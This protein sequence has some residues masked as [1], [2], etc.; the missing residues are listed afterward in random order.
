MF[1][2]D[3]RAKV[4]LTLKVTGRRPDGYHDL[5]SL[6]VFART[7]DRLAFEPGGD[8]F[9][10]VLRGP[11]AGALVNDPDNLVLR[12]AAALQALAPRLPFGRFTLTKRLPVASGLGGGSADA[13]AAIRLLARAGGLE[14]H[15]ARLVEVAL[16]TG[17]DVPVCL[18][19]KARMMRGRG[20]DLGVPI[21]LP[22]LPAL[23]VNPGVPVA[24]SAVFKAL[25][26][27]PGTDGRAGD[28]ASALETAS[29]AGLSPSRRRAEVIALAASSGNDLEAPALALEP[30]IARVLDRLR[31]DPAC[32]LARMSGSGA[33]VFGLYDTCRAAGAAAKRLRAQELGWWVKPTVFG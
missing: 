10:L 19:G 15:D 16:A 27:A 22:M 28:P 24:T 18:F 4:N 30:A 14:T 31:A 1:E 9:A 13:A 20:E 11:N 2:D 23:L 7:G 29:E 33:S 32:R 17:S 8:R 21:E 12:A 25:G 5:E 3:A 26:L 6:V